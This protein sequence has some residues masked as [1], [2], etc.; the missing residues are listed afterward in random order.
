MHPGTTPYHY[1][2]NNPLRFIDPKGKQSFPVITPQSWLRIMVRQEP[3]VKAIE[4][5]QEH[6]VD[7]TGMISVNT[8][9]MLGDF[10]S[11]SGKAALATAWDPEISFPLAT[12]SM[13]ST[14]V[15][16]PFRGVAWVTGYETEQKFKQSLLTASLQVVAHFGVEAVADQFVKESASSFSNSVRTVRAFLGS[17]FSLGIERAINDVKPED[18]KEEINKQDDRCLG[19][20]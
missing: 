9:N 17:L 8:A 18:E 6:P 14:A 12:T 11:I 15:S 2:F 7:A 4:F 1:C 10:G 3:I 5:T 13:I 16:V 20:L 19:D